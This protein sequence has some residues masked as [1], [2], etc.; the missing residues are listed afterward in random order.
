MELAHFG[1][2]HRPLACTLSA[3]IHRRDK[4]TQLLAI[5]RSLNPEM[6]KCPA[7]REAGR[8]KPSRESTL[9]PSPS[10]LSGSLPFQEPDPSG[11]S[12]LDSPEV[13]LA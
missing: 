5:R 2:L 1:K 10:E 8:L 6:V 7:V 12:E 4:K 9:D 13:D 3:T 11:H